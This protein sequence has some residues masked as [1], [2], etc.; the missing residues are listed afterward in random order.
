MLYP[1]DGGRRPKA[2]VRVRGFRFRGRLS[3]G[4]PSARP[5]MS[6]PRCSIAWGSTR[7]PN[8][9]TTRISRSPPLA[10]RRS[11]R[12]SREV[13]EDLT[14]RL[15][16]TRG[17]V[18]TTSTV[19]IAA[20]TACTSGGG[21]APA[22]DGCGRPSGRAGTDPGRAWRQPTISGPIAASFVAM[23]LTVTTACC[24]RRPPSTWPR[25]GPSV[26]RGRRVW[27]LRRFLPPLRAISIGQPRPC[28]PC[29]TT[30]LRRAGLQARSGPAGTTAAVR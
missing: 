22:L 26:A 24:S 29:R 4:Q 8:C 10:A 12:S 2:R 19:T 9:A 23:T 15:T 28:L 17:R 30:S 11:C 14:A 18:R 16:S 20:A 7:R 21:A 6:R 3:Q 25:S 5:T 1:A 13:G 27:V